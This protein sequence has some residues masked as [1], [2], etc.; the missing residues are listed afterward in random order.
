MY[1]H[2]SAEK[3]DPPPV[4][5]RAN[6]PQKVYHSLAS[7]TRILFHASRFVHPESCVLFRAFCFVQQESGI[8]RQE[9]RDRK[10]ETGIRRQE[11]GDRNQETGIKSQETGDRNRESG[12]TYHD[13]LIRS[14]SLF[15][16]MA[17]NDDGDGHQLESLNP[18][19]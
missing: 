7:D 14:L 11:S 9:T 18:L 4:A 6:A 8:R 3:A 10:Q 1:I 12:I 15:G 13:T 17:R 16:R 2:G 19:S 5:C